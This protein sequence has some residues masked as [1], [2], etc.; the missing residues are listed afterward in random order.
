[1][2]WAAPG[3]CLVKGNTDVV[4]LGVFLL[5]WC[6]CKKMVV[7]V[8]FRELILK[9]EIDLAW[10]V[11]STVYLY[12]QSHTDCY[13]K[14]MRQLFTEGTFW[15]CTFFSLITFKILSLNGLLLIFLKV[16][17]IYMYVIRIKLLMQEH[18]VDLK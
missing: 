8:F 5:L 15:W 13:L 4:G 14:K 7:F 2:L 10:D 9:I 18:L 16:C 6:Q 17:I 12:S 11:I 3:V 1:M